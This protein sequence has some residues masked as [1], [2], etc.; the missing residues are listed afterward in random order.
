MQ[1]GSGATV[2][3]EGKSLERLIAKMHCLQQPCTI[4]VLNVSG[5]SRTFSA[6]RVSLSDILLAALSKKTLS[7]CLSNGLTCEATKSRNGTHGYSFKHGS[8][9]D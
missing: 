1:N 9:L 4:R 7:D 8:Q 3:D 2:K 5:G 6:Q